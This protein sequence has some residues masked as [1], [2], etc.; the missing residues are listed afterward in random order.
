MHWLPYG[1]PIQFKAPTASLVNYKAGVQN[2]ANS[3]TV[4]TCFNCTEDISVKLGVG[5]VNVV[6]DA[7]GY[8]YPKP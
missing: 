6:I 3:G 7:L 8:Y 2:I 4:K 1:I 5:Y